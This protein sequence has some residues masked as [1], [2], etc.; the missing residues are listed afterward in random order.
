MTSRMI[1]KIYETLDKNANLR[2]KMGYDQKVIDCFF[3]ES[4]RKKNEIKRNSKN[5]EDKNKIKTY[6]NIDNKNI[7]LII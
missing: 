5:K 1:C 3:K 6:N 7:N 2:K 4:K